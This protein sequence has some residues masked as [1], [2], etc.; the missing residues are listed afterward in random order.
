MCVA[1]GA[2]LELAA[3][4]AISLDYFVMYKKRDN[5]TCN[6]GNSAGDSSDKRDVVFAIRRSAFLLA[7]LIINLTI[8]IIGLHS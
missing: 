7:L 2:M 6:S 3:F 5:N 4:V 1:V 8:V